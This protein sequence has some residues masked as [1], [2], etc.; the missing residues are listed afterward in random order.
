MSKWAPVLVELGA[1]WETFRGDGDGEGDGDGDATLAD[2]VDG[3]IPRLA[4]RDV[5]RAMR[6]VLRRRRRPLLVLWDIENVGI[7][8]R[9]SASEAVARIK[10]AVAPHGEIKQFRAYADIAQGNIPERKRSELHL[11]G[12]TL[13]DS[14]HNG[15]GSR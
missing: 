13:V 6:G 1:S 14:T 8:A 5:C 11:S 4:A 10:E 9:T 12:C 7:P 2:L 3:G 15:C